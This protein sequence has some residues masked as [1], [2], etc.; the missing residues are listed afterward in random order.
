MSQGSLISSRRDFLLGSA[1]VVGGGVLGLA[2][3]GSQFASGPN[4]ALAASDIDIL[5]YAL[6][7]EHLEA[8]FYTQ[9][10]N[11]FSRGEFQSASFIRGFGG[12]VAH[13]VY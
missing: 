4:T 3:A 5:N 12:R 7:L 13:Q 8:A 10:L 11:R 6:T 2:L 1:K 9:G